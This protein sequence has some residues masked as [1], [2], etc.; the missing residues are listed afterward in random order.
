LKSLRDL[1][2]EGV[3]EVRIADH[4]TVAGFSRR[5]MQVQ[6]TVAQISGKMPKPMKAGV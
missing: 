1:G 3:E 5:P 2:A 4:A 6:S